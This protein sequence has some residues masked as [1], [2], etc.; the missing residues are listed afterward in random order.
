M[1]QETVGTIRVAQI[2]RHNDHILN[3]LRVLAQHSCRRNTC[4]YALANLDVRIVDLGQFVRKERLQLSSLLGILLA[5]SL[6]NSLVLCCPRAQ[7]LATLC[8]QLLNLGE[9]LER[10]LGITTQA[11]NRRS[12]INT[13]LAQRLT[14]SRNQILAA[15]TI[16]TN[17]TLTHHGLTN[18]QCR[19]L[20]LL[21]CC[22]QCRTNLILRM[23]VDAHYTP[24]PSLI[25]SYNILSINLLNRGRELNIVGIVVHNQIVQTQVTSQTTYTL[26]YLLLDT[27]VRD[28]CIGL[29]SSPLAKTGCDKALGDSR[30]D[31]HSVTLTQRTRRVLDT[32]SYIQLG[33]TGGY[34]T[35]LAELAQLVHREMT[36][37]CQ[38]AI[39]HRRHMTGI[40]EK[41]I[42]ERIGR[43]IG[44]VTQKLRIEH[45]D[46]ISST[47][48]TAR[49]TRFGF[50]D[51][52]G[53]QYTNII[54][55]CFHLIS[56][57]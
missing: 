46:K 30:T 40:E 38:H 12:Y 27:T 36:R 29:V 16:G 10:I 15:R 39:Q 2:G 31:C 13:C 48:C 54:G 1:L 26:R 18:D 47:H 37:Q 53:S 4:C 57:H 14:V 8:I 7:L 19:T 34:A 49:V 22:L 11:L 51:H 33:M 9:D 17:C 23:T 43:I 5:P 24:A 50:F 52:C 42:T 55:C 44:I 20:L 21:V 3:L 35:P 45:I 28:I 32:T 56:S 6:T 41:A 25:F